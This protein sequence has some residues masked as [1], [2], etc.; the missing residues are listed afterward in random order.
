MAARGKEIRPHNQ[1][2]VGKKKKRIPLTTMERKMF[3]VT[4]K[5]QHH[6]NLVLRTIQAETTHFT[7]RQVLASGSSHVGRWSGV[8]AGQKLLLLHAGFLSPLS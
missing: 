6:P 1:R 2:R 8:P 3:K 4:R 5:T 7:T